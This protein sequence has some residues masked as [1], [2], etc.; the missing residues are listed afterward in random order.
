MRNRSPVDES[1]FCELSSVPPQCPHCQSDQNVHEISRRQVRET[2]ED[3]IYVEQKI[4]KFNREGSE[5][6]ETVRIP[7]FQ[8]RD[9]S[10]DLVEYQCQTC[11]GSQ[12]ARENEISLV[13]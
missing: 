5:S 7:E 11:G 1:L 3:V 2:V 9:V 12:A 4:K 10:V 8:E 6:M 13:E